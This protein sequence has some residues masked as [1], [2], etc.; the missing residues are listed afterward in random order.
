MDLSGLNSEQQKAVEITEGPVLILAGA[1]SGKTRALTHRIAYLLDDRRVSP[2]EILALTF[3]NKAAREMKERVEVLAGETGTHV[4]VS[5]F[6][7]CCARILR[8]DIEQ[9]GVFTRD[10]VIYDDTDQLALIGQIQ[11]TMN[12]KE[13]ALSKRALKSMFSDAKNRS[14]NPLEYLRQSGLAMQDT[15]VEAYQRYNQAL[16]KNNALDFDDLLLRTLE[17]FQ[18]VPEVLE[19]YQSRFRYIHVDEYQDTNAMQYEFVRLLSVKYR[20]LCVVGDDDQSIYGWRGADLNNILDFEQDYPD[21]TVIRLEQNYRSTKTILDA[22]NSVIS[23]NKERKQKKLWTEQVEGDKIVLYDAFSDRDEADFVCRTITQQINTGCSYNDFAVLYRTNAQ[24][25]VMED[26]LVAYGIPYTVYGSLRFYD[27][28]EIKDVLAYLRLMINPH[29]DVSLRRVINVP[30]RGIGDASVQ[31]LAD[32]AEIADI[33]MFDACLQAKTLDIT[34]RAKKKIVE[35]GGLLAQLRALSELLPLSDFMSEMLELTGYW[36]YLAEEKRKEG[37]LEDTRKENVQEL[38]NA[39]VEFEKNSDEENVLSAFLENVALVANVND[40]SETESVTLMTMHSAKG[41]EFPF[42]FLVGVEENIFPSSRSNYSESLLEE[43]RRLCYVAITRAMQK[44]YI[45]H[46]QSRMQFGNFVR[47]AP[48]R[49]LGE[50]PGDLTIE[51]VVEEA[52]LTNKSTSMNQP[53]KQGSTKWKN[54]SYTPP[55]PTNIAPKQRNSIQFEV[56]Q[57]V[58]H[59]KFGEGKIL[60]I[61]GNILTIVFEKAGTKKIVGSY[62]PLTVKE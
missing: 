47:H 32:I 26:T 19:K 46:A 40:E 50:I 44:L 36:I 35:F 7:A 3:T 1:G 6:H 29:D 53:T 56:D 4:W 51:E 41:L 21:A 28:R 39:I 14:L 59:A 18:R 27:R 45:S 31:E 11:Q 62:A 2:Y 30:K 43:E 12:I 8:M 17:L 5:T 54:K 52:F 38:L 9:M 25:R 33:S 23:Q 60:S 15:Y 13:E 48:S 61:E 10:F 42:V 24:S 49:F 22:A 16:R 57:S 20:N 34:S 55:T 37:K 58:E